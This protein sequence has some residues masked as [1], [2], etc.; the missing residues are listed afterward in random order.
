MTAI[1]DFIDVKE[2]SC[3]YTATLL[4][5]TGSASGFYGWTLEARINSAFNNTAA[6]IDKTLKEKRNNSRRE[7][8]MGEAAHP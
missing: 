7:D 5:S 1:I 4:V 2:N 3:V 6:F 8:R